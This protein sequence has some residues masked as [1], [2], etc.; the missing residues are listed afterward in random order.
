[1][2]NFLKIG[3]YDY[4]AWHRLRLPIQIIKILLYVFVRFGN[5]KFIMHLQILENRISMR[6]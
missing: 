1:M 4:D 6:V 3:D 5:Y 2:Y